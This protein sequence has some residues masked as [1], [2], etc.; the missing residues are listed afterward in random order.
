MHGRQIAGEEQVPLFFF[1]FSKKGRRS[2]DGAASGVRSVAWV[3]PLG[4]ISRI[5]PLGGSERSWTL[6][7]VHHLAT[8]QESVVSSTKPSAL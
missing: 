6:R 2:P 4:T 1:T 7:T 5:G 3:S 8:R